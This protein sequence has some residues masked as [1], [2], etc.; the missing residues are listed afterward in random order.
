[1]C[2]KSLYYAS[3]LF[4]YGQNGFMLIFDQRVDDTAYVLYVLCLATAMQ[5]VTELV[6][7]ACAEGLS[8]VWGGGMGAGAFAPGSPSK[9]GGGGGSGEGHAS[10]VEYEMIRL[11]DDFD[12][13]AAFGQGMSRGD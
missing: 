13:S 1:M 9:G 7:H 8:R 10:G 4:F 5:T 6:D 12:A 3:Y 11:T 2:S